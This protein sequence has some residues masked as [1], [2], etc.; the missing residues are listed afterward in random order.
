MATP[1]ALVVAVAE[2]VKVPEAPVPG[3][4][5]VTVIPETG[6]LYWSRS[7]TTSG[8]V[9]AVPTVADCGVPETTLSVSLV[10]LAVLVSEKF[11]VLVP[12]AEAPTL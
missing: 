4:V 8:L 9:K 11:T 5:K 10:V 12:V 7:L 3:G 6:L 2:V 1:L